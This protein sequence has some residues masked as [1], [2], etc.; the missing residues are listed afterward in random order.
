[1]LQTEPHSDC[2]TRSLNTWSC[3]AKAHNGNYHCKNTI[4]VPVSSRIKLSSAYEDVLLPV[5]IRYN[6]T[7]M[8]AN[9]NWHCLSPMLPHWRSWLVSS[10]QYLCSQDPVHN[11]NWSHI[12]CWAHLFL[13]QWPDPPHSPKCKEERLGTAFHGLKSLQNY[14]QIKEQECPSIPY[15]SSLCVVKIQWKEDFICYQFLSIHKLSKYLVTRN[16]LASTSMQGCI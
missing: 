10:C 3:V 4:F 2:F 9:E 13:G 12:T 7:A 16:L 6:S 1:M 5:H 11:L 14:R 15:Q 8:Q